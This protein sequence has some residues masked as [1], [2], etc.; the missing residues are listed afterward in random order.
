[1]EGGEFSIWNLN[2][3]FLTLCVYN[4]QIYNVVVYIFILNTSTL[5]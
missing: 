3:I 4:I 2:L 1:M 5:I